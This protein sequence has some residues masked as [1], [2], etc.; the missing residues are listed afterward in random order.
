MNKT[1]KLL[2]KV[3]EKKFERKNKKV[4]YSDSESDSDMNDDMYDISNKKNKM[5]IKKKY[6]KIQYDENYDWTED[7]VKKD[8]DV[9]INKNASHIPWIERFRPKTLD[10]VMGHNEFTST[11]KSYIEKKQFPNLVLSGPPGTGKTSTILACAKSMYKDNYSLM[12]LDI[13]ASEERGIDVI[14][15]KVKKFVSSKGVFG[16]SSQVDFKLVILDEADEL[17][18]EAQSYLIDVIDQFTI[19]ARFCLIGNQI[20]KIRL[21]IQSRCNAIKF[22]PLGKKYMEEKIIEIANEINFKV[23][24][25]GINTLIKISHG[26]MRKIINTLQSTYMASNIINEETVSKCSG[27]PLPQDIE[28]IISAI[29]KHD[30]SHGYT[31][32]NQIVK[33]NGYSLMDITNELYHKYT[34]MYLNDE[35]EPNFDIASLINYMKNIETNLTMCQN[36]N[37]QSC[38]LISAFYL[39]SQ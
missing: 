11:L 13:N 25:S 8:D 2:N 7:F 36:E 26:D 6:P 18:S 24:K 16:D 9:C 22:P 37:I 30:I 39:C 34:E 3:N 4:N 19:N 31:V 15:N 5:N 35:L 10:D 23:T 28:T 38:G 17:T 20:K 21:A 33:K 29:K 1:T 12:V 32:L 14:R 27:Y